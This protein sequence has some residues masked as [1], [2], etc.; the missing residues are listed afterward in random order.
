[1]DL[2]IEEAYAEW[3]MFES[4]LNS[5]VLTVRMF[6]EPEK[7]GF[8]VRPDEEYIVDIPPPAERLMIR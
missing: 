1:M 4:E 6:D 2:D 3:T 5:F 7:C 8:A